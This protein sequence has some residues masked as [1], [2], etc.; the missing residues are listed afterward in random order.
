M[1]NLCCRKRETV[2]RVVDHDLLLQELRFL[3]HEVKSIA[4]RPPKIITAPHAMDVYIN[5][6]DIP[7]VGKTTEYRLK[8]DG[9]E[10]F[11]GLVSHYLHLQRDEQNFRYFLRKNKIQSLQENEIVK[12]LQLY[13]PPR[14]KVL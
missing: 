7:H 8:E 10:D 12:L 6:A 2:L 3:H 5:I 1:G 4:K 11:D 13:F 9:I 14:V